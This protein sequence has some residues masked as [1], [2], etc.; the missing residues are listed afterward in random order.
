MSGLLDASEVKN[1]IEILRWEYLEVKKW[2][3]GPSW[4]LLF[5]LVLLGAQNLPLDPH[6]RKR[7]G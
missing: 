2:K 4:P 5:C 7:E 6:T 3:E 1:Q